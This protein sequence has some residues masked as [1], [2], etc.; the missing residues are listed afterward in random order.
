MKDIQTKEQYLSRLRAALKHRKIDDIDDIIL[1]YEDYFAQ[2]AAK[3]YDAAE[4]IRRLP[5]VDMLAKSYLH[6]APDTLDTEKPSLVTRSA[7]LI[8]ALLGDILLLPIVTLA[9]ALLVCIAA[10]GIL[11]P[12]AGVCML[13]PHSWLGTINVTHP[14]LVQLLP[15]VGLLI[16]GGIATLGAVAIVVERSYAVLRRSLFYHYHIYSGRS[17]NHLK[18]VPS[19]SKHTRRLLFKVVLYSGV[20]IATQL[21]L[22]SIIS[23]ITDGSI[24][25]TSTW[26]N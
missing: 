13:L 21:V 2:T 4:S 12:I 14:P 1:D 16:A 10:M 17:V 3:G 6:E 24:H 5:A 9:G 15:A 19:I 25:F 8:G 18:F 26:R 20:A 22:L 11:L 23:L 7:K